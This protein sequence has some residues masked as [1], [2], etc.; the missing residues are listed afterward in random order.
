MHRLGFC[1][2]LFVFCMW[3]WWAEWR[4][5]PC[6]ILRTCEYYFM[7]WK[8]DYVKNL[9]RKHLSCIIQMVPVYNHMYPCKTESEGI[10]KHTEEQQRL[11]W[12]AHK[13]VNA[14]GWK[15]QRTDSP[16]EPSEGMQP[17][18]HLDFELQVYTTERELISVVLSHSVCD[19]LLQQS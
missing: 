9:E 18:Q 19:N 5:R 11:K 13:P 14:W 6:S 2:C 7:R 17:C 12:Y 16:L 4:S 15:R 8:N 3:L 1:V 10:L